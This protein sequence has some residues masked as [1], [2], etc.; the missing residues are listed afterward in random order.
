[1]VG[2]NE[3]RV[4]IQMRN[5][6]LGPEVTAGL[7]AGCPGLSWGGLL[8]KLGKAVKC[9]AQIWGPVGTWETMDEALPQAM[10]FG[11]GC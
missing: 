5:T 4:S 1:M 3:T 9:T 11:C 10:A 8:P 6:C 2:Q 7:A